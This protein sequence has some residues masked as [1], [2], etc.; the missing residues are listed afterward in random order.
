[1]C[2]M[3]PHYHSFRIPLY[4]VQKRMQLNHLKKN[5]KLRKYI[6]KVNMYYYKKYLQYMLLKIVSV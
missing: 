4:E 6:S 3:A 2:K 5:F 1:M